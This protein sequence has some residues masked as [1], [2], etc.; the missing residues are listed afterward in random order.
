MID[1]TNNY[2]TTTVQ[3]NWGD[4]WAVAVN[5]ETDT[6][7]VANK[8][9]IGS[10]SV[11]AGTNNSVTNVTVGQYPEA[12][13]VNPSSN[14]IY[15]SNWGDGTV[16]VINETNLSGTPVTVPVALPTRWR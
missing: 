8:G 13:A 14:M 7:Y 4:P 6:I 3:T 10:V 1:E 12:V 2:S 15:V 11:I 5:A 9:Q 16:S